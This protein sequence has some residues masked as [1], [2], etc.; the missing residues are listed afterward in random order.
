MAK[1]GEDK[2]AG[3]GKKFDA[4][5]SAQ[6]AVDQQQFDYADEQ[7]YNKNI[8]DL[9]DYIMQPEGKKNRKKA[10][11]RKAE[12]ETTGDDTQTESVNEEKP[13]ALYPEPVSDQ[14]A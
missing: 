2:R 7:V 5:T 13:Q 12:T 1:R 6:A 4:A 11:K 3:N 8:D 14:K 9:M 10:K